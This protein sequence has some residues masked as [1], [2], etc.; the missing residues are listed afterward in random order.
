M[1]SSLPVEFRAVVDG[2]VSR[3]PSHTS[4]WRL[5]Q[6]NDKCELFIPKLSGRGFDITVVADEDE[7]TVYSEHV[8]HQHFTSEGNHYE[9]SQLAMGF[10][11]D[12]LSPAMRVRVTKKGDKAVRGDFEMWREGAWHRETTTAVIGIPK[13]R[14]KIVE[15]YVNER[16]PKRDLP[17]GSE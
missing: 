15:Y 17:T 13:F 8:A 6:K 11:R 4:D 7:V 5:E 2:I 10:V 12:L 14:R 9:T 16:L 1:P 3:D